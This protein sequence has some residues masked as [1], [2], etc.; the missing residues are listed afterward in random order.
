MKIGVVGAGMVGSASAYA[1]AMM[2]V[3]STIVLVDHD[4]KLATAQAEDIAHGTPFA[5]PVTVM[6]GGYDALEGAAVVVISAGVSQKPGETRLDLLDRNIEVFKQVI[7]G[8]KRHA[9]KAILLIAT[10]PVDVMTAVA[11][12][13]SGDDP[14]RVI[15]SGTILDTARFRHLLGR[16]LGVASQSVH[17]YVMGEHGDSEVCVW[18]SAR[19]GSTPLKAVATRLERPLTPQ[20][21]QKIDTQ[22]REAAYSIIDGKGSTYYGIGAGV[23]RIVRAILDDERV[24]FTVSVMTHGLEGIDNIPLS[25]P[26]LIGRDGVLADLPVELDEQEAE[27]LRRSA[28]V[29]ADY[30]PQSIG[31]G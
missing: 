16:H 3:G 15:G 23:A 13:L 1:M 20:I 22:V 24:V 28:N 21:C 30:L 29:I 12:H 5:Q 17:A 8:I 4:E 9:P 10:N 31:Q 6:A 11:L 26:R 19:V 18:S 14:S 27:A 7:D 2:G 25:L